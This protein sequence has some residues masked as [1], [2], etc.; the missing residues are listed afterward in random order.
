MFK[1]LVART[2]SGIAK[3][4]DLHSFTTASTPSV[5]LIIIPV[6]LYGSKLTRYLRQMSSSL[7][8]KEVT[9]RVATMLREKIRNMSARPEGPLQLRPMGLG[10]AW[11]PQTPMIQRW[12]DTYSKHLETWRRNYCDDEHRVQQGCMLSPEHSKFFLNFT[13]LFVL[14]Y[15]F[16]SGI[17]N[18]DFVTNIRTE[19]SQMTMIV[20]L[21]C[22]GAM[23]SLFSASSFLT[24]VAKVVVATGHCAWWQQRV[25]EQFFDNS[26]KLPD[27]FEWQ[28][29]VMGQ[30]KDN[31]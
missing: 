30:L 12:T 9:Y 17:L 10:A 25:R 26:W 3:R 27:N 31:C 22:T 1:G 5:K 21:K 16:F 2:F 6:N 23:M 18:K 13:A 19:H 15:F 28:S 14:F 8:Y 11:G 20:A 7:R 29:R 24:F 4:W